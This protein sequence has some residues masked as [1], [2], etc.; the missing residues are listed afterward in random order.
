MARAASTRSR[1]LPL[2]VILGLAALALAVI[3]SYGDAMR[4]VRTL[5]SLVLGGL[6][7]FALLVWLAIFA[8]LPARL[9]LAVIGATLAV[10]AGGVG[11]LRVRGVT[12]D[13]VP[14]LEWR[15]TGAPSAVAVTP[16]P[17]MSAQV[18]TPAITPV[19]GGVAPAVEPASPGVATE[20]QPVP[21]PTP[22]PARL[23]PA[24]R[25]DWP[26]FLGPKRDATL[27]EVRLDPDWEAH[28][29]KE[30]WR[31]ALGAGWSSFA[32]AEGLAITQD[33]QG[34]QERLVALELATGR[35]R[36][37]FSSRAR[38]AT[39]IA[40]E[41]P[42][43]TPSIAGGRVLAVGATGLLTALDLATGALLWQHDI[44]EASGASQPDW[45][46]SGS[47][48]VLDGRVIVSAGGPRGRSLLA[49]DVQ[50]GKELWA[51]GSDAVS[52]SSPI[53]LTL[54]GQ[55]QV[56]SFNAASVSAHQPDTGQVLW[57][58]PFPGGQPN[59]SVPLALGDDLL[60]SVG[61][62]VGSKRYRPTRASDG[63]WST[64]LL[65]ESPRLKSKFANLI[66]HGGFVYGLDDGVLT[67]LDPADG[68]R[69]FKAGRYGHGQLLQLGQHLLVQTED[70]ELVLLD[71][72]PAGAHERARFRVFDGKLWNP[73]AFVSPYLLVRNDR[74]AVL[75][76][77][78][79]AGD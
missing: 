5:L 53:A 65:W 29:P 26:Q 21:V 70:G 42:R 10:V 1:L 49:Y 4:Q 52:Y 67:C 25:N 66:R 68:A 43:A 62:G 75:L 11:L 45:G 37:T 24:P 15:F 51:A 60:V 58:Q 69:R 19:E 30:V 41:G 36:W 73:P 56:V 2:F 34:E 35:V 13:F 59:V 27:P 63:T 61:Y 76:R 20:A 39:V 16:A 50:S 38:Y 72:T 71:A 33:Q 40:G 12:G 7:T 9:R 17:A 74:E 18:A 64:S 44:V 14:L 79:L 32:V 47:P 46:R 57:E 3:W 28:P 77:L 6:T 8:G 23:E 48:L 31:S 55:P 78:P 54:H 22:T